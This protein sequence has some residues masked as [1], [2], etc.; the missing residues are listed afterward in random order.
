ME[1]HLVWLGPSPSDQAIQ[2]TRMVLS[3]HRDRLSAGCAVRV[4]GS[5]AER[6]A[7]HWFINRV[8]LGVGCIDVVLEKGLPLSPITENEIRQKALNFVAQLA[9]K[10]MKP[11]QQ[12]HHVAHFVIDTMKGRVYAGA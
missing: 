2:Q 3:Q 10:E 6:P 11:Q 4:K 12:V 7:E 1:I 9:D 5:T 8:V